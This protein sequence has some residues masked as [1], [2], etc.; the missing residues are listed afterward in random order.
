MTLPDTVAWPPLEGRLAGLAA[1]ALREGASGGTVT[2]AGFAFVAPPGPVTLR[3]KWYV[4]REVESFPGS[5]ILL[6]ALP[7]AQF[8]VAG[9]LA[10]A[11]LL[12]NLQVVPRFTVAVMVTWPPLAGV[13]AG[14]TLNAVTDGGRLACVRALAVTGAAITTAEASVAARPRRISTE[15]INLATDPL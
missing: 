11:G 10:S 13:T 7:P 14:R 9:S 12:E 8:R 4:S 5:Q 3:P 15:G 1:K 2:V 6:L